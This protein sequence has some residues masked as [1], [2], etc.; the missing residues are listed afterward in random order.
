MTVRS[1]SDQAIGLE[2]SDAELTEPATPG[3]RLPCHGFV[4]GQYHQAAEQTARRVDL[5]LAQPTND[6]L[7]VDR[8]RCRQIALRLQCSDTID[9]WPSAE[10]VD[11]HG[12]IEKD[13]HGSPSTPLV[14]APL[15]TY[16]AGR[17]V[18][19][20]VPAVI[21]AG[22]RRLQVGPPLLLLD[23]AL[24]GLSHECA[25]A[26]GTGELVHF[27]NELIVQFYVHSHVQSLA[28]SQHSSSVVKDTREWCG[29][30]RLTCG[31][32]YHERLHRAGR[33]VDEWPDAAARLRNLADQQF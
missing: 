15:F 32:D 7:D 1:G 5:G 27:R 28:H 22:G 8:G 26:P 21:D 18:V 4:D 11:E 12:R 17:V 24:D 6:F 19:P 3:T 23:G 31:C 33:G 9:S 16:P 10:I 30:S 25:P 2:E 14:S 20:R 29:V 13:Q